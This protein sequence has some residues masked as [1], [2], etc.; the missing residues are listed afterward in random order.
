MTYLPRH[1]II[2]VTIDGCDFTTDTELLPWVHKQTSE[3]VERYQ[4]CVVR[5]VKINGVWFDACAMGDDFIEEMEHEIQSMPLNAEGDPPSTPA[6]AAPVAVNPTMIRDELVAAAESIGMRFP[7]PVAVDAAPELPP[8]SHFYWTPKPG[9]GLDHKLGTWSGNSGPHPS[10]DV[11]PYWNADEV[12]AALRAVGAG[13]REP[14]TEEQI[15]EE[16]HRTQQTDDASMVFDLHD[17]SAG[18]RFAEN[19]HGIAARGKA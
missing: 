5:G 18:V 19:A 9:S 8:P 17:F 12:L 14:L 16:F 4:P 15:H 3:G 6:P 1:S 7:A 11:T 2:G 13:S 10:W